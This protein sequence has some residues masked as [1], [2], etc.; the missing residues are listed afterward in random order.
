MPPEDKNSSNY[1][2]PGAFS[3]ESSS[4]TENTPK[5]KSLKSI[6]DSFS[7]DSIEDNDAKLSPNNRLRGLLKLNKKTIFAGGFV[8]TLVIAIFVSLNFVG[9][10]QLLH[11]DGFISGK[12]DARTKRILDRRASAHYKVIFDEEGKGYYDR[13]GVRGIISKR[14]SS[15]SPSKIVEDLRRKGYD[16]NLNDEGKLFINGVEQTGDRSNRR[17]ALSSILDEEYPNQSFIKRYKRTQATFKT[18]GIKRSFFENTKEKVDNWELRTIKK[19]RERMGVGTGQA[20]IK[21]EQKDKEITDESGEKFDTIESLQDSQLSES[22]SDEAEKLKNPEYKPNDVNLDGL[23]ERLEL[24]KLEGSITSQAVSG[25]GGGVVGALK[26]TGVLDAACEVKYWVK[27]VELGAKAYRYRALIQYAS[28]ILVS[29]HQIKTGEGV[30]AAQVAG[31]MKVIN[32]SPGMGSSGAYKALSGTNSEIKGVD[33]YGLSFNSGV[34]GVFNTINSLIDR[35]NPSGV[36]EDYCQVS[37]NVAFQAGSIIIGAGVAIGTAGTS[38]VAG[39]IASLVKGLVISVGGEIVKPLLIQAIA[40]GVINGYESGDESGDALVAGAAMLASTQRYQL[41]APKISPEEIAVIENNINLERIA[42]NKNR[43]IVDKYFNP[44][45]YDSV[46]FN[47]IMG[48]PSTPKGLNRELKSGLSNVASLPFKI[49]NFRAGANSELTG[50][51]RIYNDFGIQDFGWTDEKVD[52]MEDPREIENW[53]YDNNLL[54]AYQQWASKCKINPGN[55]DSLTSA[56]LAITED[57]EIL[58]KECE[59]EDNK[60]GNR[61]SFHYL[62]RAL[63]TSIAFNSK[64]SD[65]LDPESEEWDCTYDDGG[66]P[67]RVSSDGSS[68]GTT[69]LPSGSDAEIIDKLLNNPN[70][71]WADPE[72]RRD[73]QRYNSPQINRVLL[74]LAESSGHKIIITDSYRPGASDFHGQGKALDLDND[75]RS[76]PNY[77]PKSDELFKFIYDNREVYKLNEL[78]WADPPPGTNCID[79]PSPGDRRLGSCLEIY[80]AATTVQHNNHIHLA[81]D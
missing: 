17:S 70:I 28:I 58:L 66:N 47:L 10:F 81:V 19:I 3:E 44:S 52:S 78:I 59:D 42:K 35:L 25:V 21:S 22:A 64:Q 76:G 38:F 63:S 16:I 46:A 29:S 72:G 57:D 24:S 55:E 30:D 53:I 51:A 67:E 77:N 41:G 56:G 69:T 27:A 7:S 43:S 37:R 54:E 73:V 75:S 49:L 80:G 34:G 48:L 20:S 15:L 79:S 23:G 2:Q 40:G 1:D 33:K 5:E 39:A 14:Y 11:I 61:F 13:K 4:L 32:R 26:V 60:V 12:M 74:S 71:Q 9:I 50:T 68:G 6:E 45:N 65:C 31:L 8:F 36:S 18:F 62:D